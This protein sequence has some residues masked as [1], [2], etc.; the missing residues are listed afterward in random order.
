VITYK[1]TYELDPQFKDCKPAYI[2]LVREVIA[3][4]KDKLSVF[5]LPIQEEKTTEDHPFR[6]CAVSESGNRELKLC[7]LTHTRRIYENIPFGFTLA[8]IEATF[9]N[10]RLPACRFTTFKTGPFV[11]GLL[12]S[13]TRGSI[14]D[15]NPNPGTRTIKVSCRRPENAS[16]LDWTWRFEPTCLNIVRILNATESAR[17]LTV[18]VRSGN[19][20]QVERL[21]KE[22]FEAIGYFVDPW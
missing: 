6:L 15:L 10:A 12:G 14:I 20:K 11:S 19:R 9:S 1:A 7:V 21:K 18:A 5:A 22:M 2:T 16:S 8:Q 3:R 17:R 4:A 13:V